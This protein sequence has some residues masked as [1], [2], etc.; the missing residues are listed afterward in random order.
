MVVVSAA[1]RAVIGPSALKR[2]GS[3]LPHIL[4]SIPFLRLGDVW[5]LLYA[6]VVMNWV[7]FLE[8][9]NNI[10]VYLKNQ[11]RCHIGQVWLEYQ[12]Y[13]QISYIN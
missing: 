13:S 8:R 7:V 11:T 9:K 1:Q 6:E 4:Y 5:L 2:L 3:A 12:T 10:Q